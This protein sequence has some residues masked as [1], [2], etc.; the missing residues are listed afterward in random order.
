MLEQ[1]IHVIDMYEPDTEVT[2][3]H[4]ALHGAANAALGPQLMN[5]LNARRRVGIDQCLAPMANDSNDTQCVVETL[6]AQ[7]DAPKSPVILRSSMLTTKQIVGLDVT[8]TTLGLTEPSIAMTL[9][10]GQVTLVSKILLDARR[11]KDPDGFNPTEY[12]IPY[13][14]LLN[15]QSTSAES[16]YVAVGEH[17]EGA[18][19]VAVAPVHNRES[20]CQ[21]VVVGTDI[22]Y[23]L[24]QPV[25]T[26]DAL[27]ED[28]SYLSVVAMILTLGT[29]FFYT[30][31]MKKKASLSRS[32]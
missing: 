4:H 17:V 6:E 27:P 7:N 30:Q 28:F 31:R 9:E 32:W 29:V 10:S 20:M 12:L 15:L 18:R 26:F 2:R 22:L 23:A 1:E 13:R 19:V 11:P 21:I 25:G 5:A 3:V 14:P 16:Q 24:V 8:E